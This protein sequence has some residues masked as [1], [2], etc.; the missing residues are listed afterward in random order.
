VP[1]FVLTPTSDESCRHAHP[2]L[3]LAAA[4]Y[5]PLV[6]QARHYNLV[7]DS[8]SPKPNGKH[9]RLVVPLGNKITPRIHAL[10]TCFSRLLFCLS[11]A[12]REQL[13][14]LRLFPFVL[15]AVRLES[16]GSDVRSKVDVASLVGAATTHRDH[17]PAR[18]FLCSPQLPTRAL[19]ARVSQDGGA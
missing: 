18:L 9:L 19:C 17:L 13:V 2:S 12:H 11:E 1:S 3:P 8:F 5:P 14:V 16:S 4:F 10:V 15:G 6:Y 7:H